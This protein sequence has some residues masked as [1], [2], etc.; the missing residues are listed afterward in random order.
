MD[1]LWAQPRGH[2][3]DAQKGLET[4]ESMG[5]SVGLVES[6]LAGLNDYQL[7][8]GQMRRLQEAVG[9]P[10]DSTSQ[11]SKVGAKEL[12]GLI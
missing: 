7:W 6:P 9:S 1:F 12:T 11:V 4:G 5:H 8:R 10:G 2:G 3:E